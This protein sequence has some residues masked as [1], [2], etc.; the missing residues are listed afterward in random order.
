MNIYILNANV[1][2]YL[3]YKWVLHIKLIEDVEFSF[4]EG[5]NPACHV[6]WGLTEEKNGCKNIYYI[7]VVVSAVI[8]IM[9]FMKRP[10]PG[11]R[12]Q[13]KPF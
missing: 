9:F 6:S 4:K 8:K 3:T 10:F 7:R 1:V 13:K 11:L 2:E 5:M 12:G